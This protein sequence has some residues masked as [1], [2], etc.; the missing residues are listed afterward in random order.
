[1]APTLFVLISC[2][3]PSSRLMQV[4]VIAEGRGDGLCEFTFPRWVPGSYLMREPFQH[5]RDLRVCDES[6]KE[7]SWKRNGINGIIV[8]GRS[9]SNTVVLH[10]DLLCADLTVRSNHLDST[11]LHLMPPFTWFL[12]KR[13]CVWADNEVG[14][15]RSVVEENQVGVTMH[16]P[17]KWI[18]A[19]QLPPVE[20]NWLNH[21][22]EDGQTPAGCATHHFVAKNRDELLDGIVEANATPSDTI[23]INGIPHHLK[24]WDS[25]GASIDSD[26]VDRIQEAIRQIA[27]ESHRLFG[28][29]DIPD[30]TTVLQLTSGSRGG[31][32][33]LRSQTSMVP[34]KALWAGQKEGW[35]DLVSLLSHEYMHLW[36]VKDLR[37]KKYLNY[38][39]DVEQ[40]TDLLWWF[41]GGTSWLGDVICVRSGVWSE[42]DYRIDFKRKMK[43]HLRG[44]G[45]SKQTLA[46]SSHEAWIHLY[47]PNPHATEHRI[48][49]YNEGELALFCL[50][51]EIRRR[52]KGNSGLELLF[53]E[54]WK[55]HNR[56]SPNP[57][58]GEAEIFAAL[59]TIEGGSR[60]VGMLR[61]LIHE[62]GRPPVNDAM[63]TFG[64]LLTSGKEEKDDDDDFKADESKEGPSRGWL[65]LRLT[66]RSGLLKISAFEI[67]SPMRNIAQIG[68]EIVAISGQRVHTTKDV[69]EYLKGKVGDEVKIALARQGRMIPICVEVVEEPQL[70]VTIK[71]KGNRLWRSLIGSQNDE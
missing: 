22:G 40:T 52:S 67:P 56:N 69:K 48:S 47:R 25:G 30:Y 2:S 3:N 46:E 70:A 68:D 8:S 61:T 28:V 23:E 49:Y 32:E 65:G 15:H 62:K 37:P 18:P 57:G 6:G 36:N 1:M 4:S 29:P 60:L 41:E 12:P 14:R 7:L 54:L 53:A 59:H 50:D 13:G 31:L 27:E 19:T 10:Y 35:R 71:G 63:K 51:A 33:H 58:V 17:S 44:D 64:L 20:A 43:R 11:H 45:N 39:L 55:K 38:D 42:D 9:P 66:E 34:R 5:V 21:L 16:L 26:A 24:L